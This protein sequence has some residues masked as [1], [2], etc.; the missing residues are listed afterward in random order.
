MDAYQAASRAVISTY[1]KKVLL[2]FEIGAA[3]IFVL[4]VIGTSWLIV[5]YS[6]W[7]WMLMI[8][9]LPYGLIGSIIWLLIH[10]T[11]D[12]LSPVQTK[13]QRHAVAQFSHSVEHVAADIG[14]TQ[15][16]L[17]LKIIRSVMRPSQ[18]QLLDEF[19][20]SSKELKRDFEQLIRLFE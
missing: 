3:A 8:I 15:F 7:W 14:M 16:S 20:G 19:T 17:M 6:A 13:A 9:V 12:R 4:A 18:H 5:Q 1:A 11:I 2:P 10:T